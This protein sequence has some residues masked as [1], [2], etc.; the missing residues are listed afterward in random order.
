MNAKALSPWTQSMLNDLAKV[1]GSIARQMTVLGRRDDAEDIAQETFI[2]ANRRLASY[3]PAKG[4]FQ[5]WLA[6]IANNLIKQGTRKYLNESPVGGFL[7]DEVHTYTPVSADIGEMVT[8][9]IFS[10]EK[11]SRVMA[12]VYQASEHQFTV[13]RAMV[14]VRDCDGEVKEA[15]EK[16]GLT[17]ATLRHSLRAVQD[18]AQLVDNSLEVYWQRVSSGRLGEPLTVREIL[19]CFPNGDDTDHQW[20]KVIPMAVL[21]CGGWNVDSSVLVR[22]VAETTG[23]TPNTA[24][25]LINRCH[26][27]YGVARSLAETGTLE[28]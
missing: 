5:S 18:L 27:L 7:A 20:L 28:G 22:R 13:D 23:Y 1:Q 16:L 19:D 11:L 17:S 8:E 12:L 25:S 2:V 9:Q 10:A 21:R 6:G 26:R 3:D 15:A 4:A 24:R 14:L